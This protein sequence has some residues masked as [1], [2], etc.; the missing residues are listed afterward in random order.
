MK[1][2]LKYFAAANTTD[3]FVSYYDGIFGKLKKLY[4]IKGGPGTGKSR[5]MREIGASAEEKG[6][7]VE[8]FYC[9]FD[10][11]SLDG[12]IINHTCA[13]IDGTAPHV[14]EPRIPGARDETVDL[15]CFWNSKVLKEKREIPKCKVLKLYP[16]KS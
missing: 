16:D 7:N 3:G 10:P 11:A 2:D 8:Y 4:V 9:S 5:L 12:I 6:D 15:S 13:V 14:Y 1:N